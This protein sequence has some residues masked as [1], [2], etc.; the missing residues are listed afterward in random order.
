MRIRRAEPG[1]G[2]RLNTGL[3]AL[4]AEM[5]DT[6]RATD[7][8][9]EAA[10]FGPHVALY[11]LLAEVGDEVQGVVAFSP[12]LSTYRGAIG[13]YISDLWVAEAARGQGL[14]RRLLAAVRDEAARLWGPGYLRLTVY[15]HNP[16]ARRLYDRLGFTDRASEVWMVLDGQALEV[17]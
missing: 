9:I 8:L 1:E 13:V 14:G 10:C 5:G 7:A 17:L 4:S 11:G 15:A 2:A 12:Q 16:D 6:H 3:R